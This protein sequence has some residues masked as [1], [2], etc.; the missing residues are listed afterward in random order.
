MTRSPRVSANARALPRSRASTRTSGAPASRK[1]AAAPRAAPPAPRIAAGAAD[2]S[3]PL[4]CSANAASRPSPSVLSAA[5]VPSAWK[6]SMLA[7]PAH[8]ARALA[9]SAASSAASLNGAVTFSPRT[10][11]PR[12]PSKKAAIRSGPGAKGA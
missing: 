10:T 5:M 11:P 8:V 12:I 6:I 9:S 4:A 2:G 3:N 7:A 1:A